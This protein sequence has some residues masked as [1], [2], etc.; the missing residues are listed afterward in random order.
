M[1]MKS[2]ETPAITAAL[3]LE[4]NATPTRS[5]RLDRRQLL[6]GGL[7][8]AGTTGCGYILHPER[9]GR[10]GG[11]I[12]GTVL[13][14]DLLWLIPGLLPGIVCLAVDFTSGGIY[15]SGTSTTITVSSAPRAQE[16]HAAFVE[17][18]LDGVIVAAGAVSADRTAR[19]EWLRS[20]DETALRQRGQVRVRGVDGKVAQT[21]AR[22]LLAATVP[23]PHRG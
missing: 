10:T 4:P 2:N 9:R 8:L 17:V 12:D 13:I 5:A 7:A 6:V 15:G 11:T 19:L 18:E 23:V 16:R 21:D 14:F 20:V 22:D 3:A 1:P